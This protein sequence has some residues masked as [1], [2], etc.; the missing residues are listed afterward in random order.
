M[1]NVFVKPKPM[2]KVNKSAMI[3]T[4]HVKHARDS[5]ILT[6]ILVTLS[7]F[8]FLIIICASASTRIVMMEKHLCAVILTVIQPALH[9][10]YLESQIV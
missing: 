1:E 9:V 4:V 7:T 10:I 5:I 8:V 3:A 2:T 6:V